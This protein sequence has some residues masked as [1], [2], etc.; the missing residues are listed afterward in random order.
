MNTIRVAI[1]HDWLTGMRGGE[2]VLEALLDIFPNVEIFTLIFNK[3]KISDKIKKHKI[4]T[5]F[6][7]NIPG[8]FKYY[9]NF[10]PLFPLA[11]ERFNLKN[12]DLIISSS[13][14]VAKGAISRK[15]AIHIC[16]CHT[17][18]RYAYDQFDNYFSERK[19]GK[20]K[21][22]IIKKIMSDLREWDTKT[23]VRVNYF[24]ANS[25]NVRN[26][27]KKHYDREADV[28]YPPVNTDFFTP[29]ENVKKEDF[30]L[31][32]GALVEYKKPDFIVKIFSDRLK[33]K[34]LIVAGNGP[35]YEYINKIKADNI[36]LLKDIKD[37]EIRE[38]Y[39]KAR[40]F[41]FPGEEDFGMTM[42]EANACATPVLALNKGGALEIVKENITGE[43]YD[44]TGENFI[45][46]LE[47]MEKK[48]YDIKLMREN[49]LKFSKD[50][51]E[52]NLI[53]FMK[54]RNISE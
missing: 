6:L 39:R 12:F 35:L 8:I 2:K 24:I 22:W 5:S 49:A 46:K 43:F 45:L 48:L 10:L 52:A 34:K 54:R 20:L 7:Q 14:C 44:G 15:D 28:I 37:I 38:L 26:R 3:D 18:M 21:Y 27:I 50:K 16:Y 30:Y 51:F 1:V 9:R 31:M 11:I 36:I 23:S 47:K 13:H 32:V 4:H 25:E 53:K 42:V 41:I 19:N 40:V 17:P 29:D 33:N